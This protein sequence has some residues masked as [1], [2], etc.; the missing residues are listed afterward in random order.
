MSIERFIGKK[1]KPAANRTVYIVM[2]L[3]EWG[4]F[5][6]RKLR[7]KSNNGKALDSADSNFFVLFFHGIHFQW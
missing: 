7:T 6:I 5:N 2:I 1:Q 4:Q 3:S